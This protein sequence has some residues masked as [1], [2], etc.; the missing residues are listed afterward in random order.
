MIN[1]NEMKKDYI[2][3]E[4]R[5]YI[6]ESVTVPEGLEEKVLAA[7]T[8][9]RK[10]IEEIHREKQEKKAAHKSVALRAAV[11]AAVITLMILII[12][13]SRQV[14]VS[15]AESLINSIRSWYSNMN[16]ENKFVFDVYQAETDGDFL[17]ITAKE[18]LPLSDE[19]HWNYDN[20]YSYIYGD[21]S[22]NLGNTYHFEGDNKNHYY[23]YL[24]DQ[25]S[26]DDYSFD[27]PYSVSDIIEDGTCNCVYRFYIPELG[28]KFNDMSIEYKCN[29]NYALYHIDE[30]TDILTNGIE[31]DKVAWFDY[32]K[33]MD[34]N[35]L[36]NGESPVFK[37]SISISVKKAVSCIKKTIMEFDLSE[38]DNKSLKLSD[39]EES[40]LG[41][42]DNLHEYP[43]F[44]NRL[45]NSTHYIDNL[46]I[47]PI[48]IVTSDI[49]THMILEI[50]GLDNIPFN[51]INID[52]TF[53]IKFNDTIFQFD[54]LNSCSYY[55]IRFLSGEEC[56]YMYVDNSKYYLC[57]TLLSNDFEND[58]K[59]TITSILNTIDN[60][61]IKYSH[62]WLH[63]YDE[64]QKKWIYEI[65]DISNTK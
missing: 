27:Y 61:N 31:H 58:D 42:L 36:F 25:V 23:V 53:L 11:I 49:N 3:R 62:L 46:K 12:P 64:Q 10:E 5:D 1:L 65:S 32:D 48:S 34:S 21:I 30:D 52:S 56:A 40:E 54:T 44:E 2:G 17:Y 18:V 55:N 50:S 9:K 26:I 24:D 22:D 41:S 35:L 4:P 63:Y 37:K 33:L 57:L 29:L 43:E 60:Q 28:K 8:Q 15:A 47:K 13:S 7:M 59:S 6:V 19:E 20:S 39:D 16:T 45:S 51:K 14:V 38:Y